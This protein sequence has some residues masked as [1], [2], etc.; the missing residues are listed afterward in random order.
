M[1]ASRVRLS[2][3]ASNRSQRAYSPSNGVLVSVIDLCSHLFGL[4]GHRERQKDLVILAIEVLIDFEG[5]CSVMV[6]NLLLDK[7]K[8]RYFGAFAGAALARALC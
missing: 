6:P 7:V 1:S 4:V 5:F 3:K 8:A 2:R